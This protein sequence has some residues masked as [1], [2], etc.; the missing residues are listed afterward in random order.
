MMAVDRALVCRLLFCIYS[1]SRTSGWY[2]GKVVVKNGPHATVFPCNR[3]L[4]KDEDDGKIERELLPLG[5]KNAEETDAL[6]CPSFL[7]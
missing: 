4:A 5:A 2:L 1:K 6:H 3:W 7:F